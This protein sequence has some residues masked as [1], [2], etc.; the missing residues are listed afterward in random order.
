[1]ATS[2]G[3]DKTKQPVRCLAHPWQSCP[4][5][6]GASKVR[7]QQLEPSW[8]VKAKSPGTPQ[9]WKISKSPYSGDD[10]QLSRAAS[11]LYPSL[12]PVRIRSPAQW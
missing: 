10:L 5:L 12:E 8:T 3:Q 1:V 6:P 11:R 2:F 4:K 9:V 7:A